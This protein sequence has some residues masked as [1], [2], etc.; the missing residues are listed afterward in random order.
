MWQQLA[1]VVFCLRYQG[2]SIGEKQH[3]LGPVTFGKHIDNRSGRAGFS[4]ACRHH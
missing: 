4:T 3:T 1:K 2:I